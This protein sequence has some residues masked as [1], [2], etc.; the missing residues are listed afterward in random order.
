M[1]A[2]QQT[3]PGSQAKPSPFK[4]SPTSARPFPT[5]KT[6][7]ETASS[8]S[9]IVSRVLQSQG[10]AP[11]SPP[12]TGDAR[13]LFSVS[14]PLYTGLGGTALPSASLLKTPS[15][16]LSAEET[17][18]DAIRNIVGGELL[19]SLSLAE[20]LWGKSSGT[21]TSL[22]QSPDI[23]V[24]YTHEKDVQKDKAEPDARSRSVASQRSRRSG[25]TE[26]S[27]PDEKACKL[28]QL[29]TSSHAV[30]AGNRSAIQAGVCEF[31]DR[32]LLALPCSVIAL[33]SRLRQRVK[34][35][36]HQQQV[37][38]QV[39]VVSV[40]FLT[41]ANHRSSRRKFESSSTSA[42]KPCSM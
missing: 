38:T 32:V 39:R 15:T 7:P 10:R 21:S 30:P 1:P 4:R 3:S 20:V 8:A 5:P 18:R 41:A 9:T 2:R 26:T 33:A 36:E 22:W 24:E 17:R 16:S 27:V 35:L 12:A 37:S 42:R 40:L 29:R 31:V 13:N 6:P 23:S 11:D 34:L 28:Y 25:K 19:N 14:S